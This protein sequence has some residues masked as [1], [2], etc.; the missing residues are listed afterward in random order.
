MSLPRIKPRAAEPALPA[1]DE[2][3]RFRVEIASRFLGQSKATTWN[4]IRHG[5][6]VAIREGKRTFIPGS[7]ISRRCRAPS[8]SA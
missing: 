4:Q 1:F 6:L 5:D 2:R 8:A 7:E 3:L